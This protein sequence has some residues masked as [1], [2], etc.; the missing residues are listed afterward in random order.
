MAFDTSGRAPKLPTN[1]TF[2]WGNPSSGGDQVD[3]A[4][5]AHEAADIVGDLV[6]AATHHA[7]GPARIVRRDDDV[8]QLVKRVARAAP[9]G[10]V[11]AR[12]LPPHIDRRAAEPAA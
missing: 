8:G 4:V 3:E 5:A 6:P 2:I 7:A 12:I 10:L 1:E 11:G 9:V